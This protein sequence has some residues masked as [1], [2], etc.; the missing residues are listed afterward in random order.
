VLVELDSTEIVNFSLYHPEISLS[1][2]HI[3]ASVI[4]QTLDTSFSIINS[5][6]GPLD[7]AISIYYAG[8]VSPSPWD[9]ISSVPVSGATGDLQIM[10]CEFVGN[11]WWV[12]GGGGPGGQNLFYRFRRDGELLG[13]VPQPSTS[14]V[15]W[16]D[17][18]CDSQWVYG[19]EDH[20]LVGVDHQGVVR[21]SIPSPVNPSRAVAYDPAS[22]HFWVTDYLQDFYEIDRHGNI[23]QQ[24]PNSGAGALSVTGLAW[25]ANDANGY[26]LYI[27]SQNGTGTLTRVTRLNPVSPYPREFVVDLNG[28][29]GDRSGGCTITPAWNSTLVVFG[30][31]IQSSGGDRLQIHEMTFNTTWI[32]VTP[33]AF[34]IP[35]SGS[36]DVLLHFDPI[37][38]LPDTYR[39]NLHIRSE[40]LDTLILL[41]VQLTVDSPNAVQS[42]PGAVPAVFSLHQNYPNPFNPTTTVRY[43]LP[44]DGLTRLT[45]YNL[46][47]E[48]VA[49]L[50]NERQPAG[51]YEVHFD[52]ADL[53]S[54]MYFYRL[55]NSGFVKSAK[56]ILMK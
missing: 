43:D 1:T 46:L 8:D 22:D 39:V 56:M 9:S 19:S 10:G 2:D 24:I 49:E 13:T 18:A 30:G 27:F 26:K 42:L 31:I 29:T 33:A 48:Q 40:V 12:T 50:V 32:D 16:F 37:T 11:E 6:N 44:H 25:Y 35:G 53:P 15:G 45:V 28:R 14:A 34:E 55:E 54:G 21:T 7:Y 52:A 23:I 41:P 47:G 5:G 17:L 4:S 36:T 38:L 20:N 51:R 3:Q